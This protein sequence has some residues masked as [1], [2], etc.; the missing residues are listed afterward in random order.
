MYACFNVWLGGVSS[1]RASSDNIT[2]LLSVTVR[3]NLISSYQVAW[4]RNAV[5]ILLLKQDNVK[6]EVCPMPSVSSW[7]IKSANAQ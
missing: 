6:L 7:T 5:R 4:L 1:L 3:C 2:E